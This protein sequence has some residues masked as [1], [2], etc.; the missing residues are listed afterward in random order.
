MNNDSDKKLNLLVVILSCK[1]NSHLWQKILERNIDNMV[2]ICGDKLDTDYKLDGKILY[3]NCNDYYEGLPEKMICAFDAIL[4]IDKFKNITHVL[5]S[6]DHDNLFTKEN[7]KDI[8]FNSQI[9]KLDYVGQRINYSKNI[10]NTSITWHFKKCSEDSYWSNRQYRGEYTDWLDGGESYILSRNALEK[11]N[12]E[13][14]SKDK[15]NVSRVHIYEDLMVALILKKFNI[16]PIK[17]NYNLIGD[18]KKLNL[19]ANFKYF[20]T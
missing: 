16:Y 1:K 20:F 2:I 10:S 9:A 13:Y 7:I 17:L 18:K 8:S 4:R 6:D 14:S 3:L 19:N 15:D 11:I 5:K 12:S